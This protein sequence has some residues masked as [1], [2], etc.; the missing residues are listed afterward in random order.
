MSYLK[1]FVI[2]LIT[3]IVL[4]SIIT[5]DIPVETLKKKYTDKNSMFMDIDGTSVH[6]RDEKPQNPAEVI[7]LLHGT[8]SSLHTWDEWTKIL[9]KNGHRVV[10]LDLPAFGLTGPNPTNN[11]T[12]SYYVDFLRTFLSKL[13]ITTFHLVGNSLGGQIT[14]QYALE[15]PQELRSITL[16]SSAGIHKSLPFLLWMVKLPIVN[17]VL[18]YVT[19]YKIFERAINEVYGDSS[20]I[21]EELIVRYYELSLREGNRNALVHRLSIATIGNDKNLEK[22]STLKIPTLI[23]WGELDRWLDVQIASLFKEAIP[24]SILK[25]YPKAGHVPMEEIPQ[26]TTQDFLHFLGAIVSTH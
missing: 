21:S 19:P 15:H 5:P 11:Y 3:G 2:T 16:I 9:V 13:G 8:S 25:I 6:Y 10:R 1:F 22:L 12:I 14:Y 18:K 7:V 17:V 23:L 20:K 4:Y 26:Q 24:G